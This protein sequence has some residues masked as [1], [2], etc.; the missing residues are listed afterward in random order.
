MVIAEQQNI[1]VNVKEQICSIAPVFTLDQAP[2]VFV[3]NRISVEL[4][5]RN[6]SSWK[7]T[8]ISSTTKY[9]EWND[10]SPSIVKSQLLT[11]TCQ[12]RDA[13]ASSLKKQTRSAC[14][15]CRSVWVSL[16]WRSRQSW[17]KL[18]AHTQKRYPCS[19]K[20]ASW[21]SNVYQYTHLWR[22]KAPKMIRCA[23]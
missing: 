20:S 16:I 6:T 9:P 8:K 18:Q 5:F 17:A 10:R 12:T 21:D 3:S 13:R 23:S 22:L 1:Y 15:R 2:N 7:L 14:L 11:R 4:I 19:Q